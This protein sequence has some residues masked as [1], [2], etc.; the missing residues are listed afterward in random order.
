MANRPNIWQSRTLGDCGKWYSGGTPDTSNAAFWNG[1]T[2]WISASSLH[3]FYITDSERRVTSE[4]IQSGSR[5]MPADTIMFVVRGMSLKSEFR[6]GI[7]QRPVAFGQDCKAIV[8]S[9]DIDP[10]F[11]ANAI[12]AKSQE[13]LGLVDEAGHGT[14]RLQTDLMM[15]LSI[16]VPPLPVQKQAVALI[17]ALDDKIELNRRTN[18]TLEA[19]ARAL[20]QSWFVDFDPVHAK[21]EGRQLAG[22]DAATAALFPDRF[23][24]SALGEVP[25]GWRVSEIGAEVEV[26]GGSTPSTAEA[27]YW[28]GGTI[29]WATPKDLSGLDAPVLLNTARRITD[30]GLQQIGSGL[31][32]AG[33]VLLSSRA[34][35]GYLA[36][37]DIPLAINQGFIAMKCDAQLPST[38]VLNLAKA[39]METI[40]GRANGTTFMEVSKANFRTIPVIVPRANVLQVFQQTVMPW[41][42]KIAANLREVQT[43]AELRDTLL[44]KLMSGEVRVREH[45]ESEGRTPG[46]Q[47]SA[48]AYQRHLR[49]N[50][51]WRR[52]RK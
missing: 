13:I 15:G 48:E 3:D 11:L 12:R 33:T 18:Q 50:D 9:D 37:A 25:Q 1:D 28:E 43:L 20:F 30:A 16:E 22:M 10:L 46:Q 41:Y 24:D 14:G 26:V 19:L 23:E 45:V 34:P 8:P 6:V 44:P 52:G 17:A 40:E 4:G 7:T 49:P 35:V 29:D 27:A 2:P 32:P 31:L 42:E 47:A 38:Y 36:L 5:L 21:A 39:N 51:F